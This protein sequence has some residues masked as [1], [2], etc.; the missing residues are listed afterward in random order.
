MLPGSHAAPPPAGARASRQL[1]TVFTVYYDLPLAALR[2]VQLTDS[3]TVA[4]GRDRSCGAAQS[5]SRRMQS[6]L[7]YETDII[8]LV[9]ADDAPGGTFVT[10]HGSTEYARSWHRK[11]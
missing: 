1:T 6:W 9:A 11:D 10:V 2:C 8:L 5:I 4:N 3:F 7:M